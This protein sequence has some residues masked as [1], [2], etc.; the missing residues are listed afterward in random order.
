MDKYVIGIDFGTE[1]ARAILVNIASGDVSTSEVARYSDGV[2]DERLP[3]GDV[4]LPPDFALQNPQDWLC[5]MQISVSAVIREAGIHPEQVIGIG[6]DFTSCT[7]LP[8]TREGKPLC[9]LDGY[10]FQPHAWPKLWKHHAAQPQADRITQAALQQEQGWLKRYGGKVS[11]EWL[12]AKALQIL[13]EAPE[14][15]DATEVFLEGGDWIVW[16]LTGH[17]IHNA[18]AAGYKALWHKSDGFPSENYLRSLHPH[19]DRL[20]KKLAGPVRSPGFRVG[21]LSIQWANKLGLQAGIPVAAAIIDAHSAALGAGVTEPGKMFLIMGT[22]TCHMLM[23]ENEYLVP[24]IA[25]VVEDGIVPGLFG[26]EAGQVGVGDIFAWF[27]DNCTPTIY[28][29]E[30]KKRNI[31]LHTLLSEKASLLQPGQ[32]GLLALD[33]WNGNRTPLVDAG[34]SGLLI[35]ATLATKPEEI[36]RAL[37]ESTAFGT[38]W[39]IDTFTSN[40]L[41]VES[42][43]AGGG[44]VKNPMLMQIYTDVT[45][46]EISIASSSQVSALGAAL[47]AVMSSGEYSSLTEAAA[48]MVPPPAQTF[49]P[50]M[51]SKPV[52]SVLY[53]EYLRL[54]HYFG[55]GDNQLMKVLRKLR[56]GN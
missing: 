26:Y 15:Y 31:S 28:A 3:V 55:N 29:E 6:V 36:Y 35:G 54:C 21:D 8:T 25:G 22:S 46:R 12:P 18:C 33:W 40:G 2:I 30:A 34:L 23:S 17:L 13:E 48:H 52:Y 38:R 51:T 44:L 56:Q 45:Q 20:Y 50:N 39:V 10:R 24:G 5:A 9:E 47:L 14:I 43:V 27:V 41:A 53:E 4:L 16:Q 49:K 11:S 1:S 19:F 42:L 37:I 32:S 7:V